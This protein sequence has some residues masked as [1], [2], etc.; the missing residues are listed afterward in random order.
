[1]DKEVIQSI[2]A[3]LS[4]NAEWIASVLIVTIVYLSKPKKVII[5]IL[6]KIK[7]ESSR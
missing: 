4:E 7:I 1:M 3:A 6:D 2:I 5:S